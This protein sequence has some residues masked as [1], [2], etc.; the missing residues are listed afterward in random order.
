[1]KSDLDLQALISGRLKNKKQPVQLVFLVF[2]AKPLITTAAPS[3]LPWE[4]VR[5]RATSRKACIEAV[6]ELGKDC[7]DSENALSPALPHG[8][9]GRLQQVL[10]LQAV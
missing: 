1:M 2:L 10:R 7:R 4:R 3:S 8:G 5:E 6:R 9:G